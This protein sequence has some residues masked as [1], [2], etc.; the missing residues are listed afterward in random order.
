MDFIANYLERIGYILFIGAK[1]I[2]KWYKYSKYL[3]FL[4]LVLLM[5]KNINEEVINIFLII[6]IEHS[7]IIFITKLKFIF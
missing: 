6:S 1:T 5:I 3:Y 2:K 4:N 7:N